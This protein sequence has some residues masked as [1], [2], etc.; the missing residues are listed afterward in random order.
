MKLKTSLCGSIAALALMAGM[1]HA[2]GKVTV[3]EQVKK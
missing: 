3:I 2:D 1:A